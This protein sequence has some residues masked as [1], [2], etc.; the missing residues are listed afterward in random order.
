MK[1]AAVENVRKPKR[2]GIRME[3]CQNKTKKVFEKNLI[4][5][6]TLKKHV[7]CKKR[8]KLM[9]VFQ[10]GTQTERFLLVVLSES[11]LDLR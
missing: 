8:E 1:L 2:L 6:C 4:C 3:I 11:R 7:G 9:D 10:R 5:V